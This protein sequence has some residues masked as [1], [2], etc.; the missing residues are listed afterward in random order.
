MRKIMI[1]ILYVDHSAFHE[2]DFVY[3][4]TSK[5]HDWWLLLMAHTSSFFIV[6]DKKYTMPPQSVMLYPPHSI[7]HYVALE[8]S[9]KN[10]WIRFYTDEEFICNGTVPIETPFEIREF[11]FIHLL[12]EQ[13]CSE[14]F[15]ENKYKRQTV[16]ALFHLMFHKLDESFSHQIENAQTKE[17][18]ALRLN[19]KNNPGFD[20]TIPYMADQLHISPGHLHSIYRKTFG[21][22]CMEDVIQMR[23][24]LAKDYLKNSSTP[25]HSIAARC[26]YKNVEHFSRQFKKYT[27]MPPRQYRQ[28]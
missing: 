23:M 28:N 4:D 11:T 13:L 10:D 8:G 18:I 24:T 26:G 20:W 16:N 25:I 6:G 3:I 9:F 12:F 15:F 19:I 2:G 1:D 17:L 7:L 21:I 22:T 27:G 14:N 5:T